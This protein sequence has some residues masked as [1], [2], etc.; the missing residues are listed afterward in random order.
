[1]SEI[2]YPIERLSEYVSEQV[3]DLVKQLGTGLESVAA[4]NADLPGIEDLLQTVDADPVPLFGLSL[5]VQLRALINA[6][7]P[8][9][10][11]GLIHERSAQILEV[12]LGRPGFGAEL[13]RWTQAL[14][15]GWLQLTGQE[16]P[17]DWI[18]HIVAAFEAH[19]GPDLQHQ[20][21]VWAQLF[22]LTL[23]ADTYRQNAAVVAEQLRQAMGPETAAVGAS[24]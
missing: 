9:A 20:G 10:A 15:D 24:V 22:Y 6:Q 4:D 8:D 23:I 7:F 21:V 3:L 14:S 19:Y 17:D 13:Q 16:N 11:L 2:V 18:Q 5:Y 1:M 12:A